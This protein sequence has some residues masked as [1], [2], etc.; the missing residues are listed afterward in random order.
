V[1]IGRVN[2]GN[3]ALTVTPAD[4]D[5]MRANLFIDGRRRNAKFSGFWAL[6]I[7]ASV[8]AS[9]GVVGDATATVI[10][11]MIVAPLMTPILGMV[12]AIVIAD[13][14]NLLKSLMLVVAGSATAV[15]V[16]YIVGL[17]AVIDTVAATNSQVA[18]RVNPRLIDLL[19][20][21]A[22]GTVAAF[23]QC[24]D[25][26]SDALPGVAI[27]ISLVPPLAV[28]GLT[29]EAGAADEAAGAMLLFLTNVAAILVTG[30][31]VMTVYGVHRVSE[32]KRMLARRRTVA[33]LAGFLVLLVLPLAATTTRIATTTLQDSDVRSVAESWAEPANWSVVG[34]ERTGNELR[35]TVIGALPAPSIDDL[36]TNLA[37]SGYG[38]L[39]VTVDLLPVERVK[40]QNP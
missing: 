33:V 29:L 15:A 2:I 3:M 5:R 18:T 13:R 10:G 9:A 27:A 22:T 37:D 28:V 20:A 12:L 24:R 40:L 35:L 31:V 25:D 23:V 26:I 14:V 34:I 30:V 7:L 8:I 39:D 1:H 36:Q 6:L 4:I 38:N 16:G 32:S 17:L 21:L 19:A 11:A